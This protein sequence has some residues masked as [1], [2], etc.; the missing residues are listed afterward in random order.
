LT[1]KAPYKVKNRKHHAF[2][3]V[4]EAHRY[5]AWN[6]APSNRLPDEV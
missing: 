3:R 2:D 4:Q 1:R 5:N 6:N